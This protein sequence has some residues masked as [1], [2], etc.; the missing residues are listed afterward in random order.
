MTLTLSSVAMLSAE[1]YAS[2]VICRICLR[3]LFKLNGCS[4]GLCPAVYV[5]H[6]CLLYCLY[7]VQCTLCAEYSVMSLYPNSCQDFSAR[8]GKNSFRF[9]DSAPCPLVNKVFLTSIFIL[10]HLKN[11]CNHP[12]SVKK[13]KILKSTQQLESVSPFFGPF[14]T[15]SAKVRPQILKCPAGHF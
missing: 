8:L 13:K 9:S 6:K 11:L 2:P 14:W 15:N 3:Y 1:L 10:S 7:T 5:V 12:V 4:G